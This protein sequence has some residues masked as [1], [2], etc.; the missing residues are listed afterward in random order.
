MKKTKILFPIFLSILLISSFFFTPSVNATISYYNHIQNPS[1][2]SFSDYIEDGSFESGEY[3]SGIVYGNWTGGMD[4]STDNP[5]TGIYSAK[6]EYPSLT[7]LD[8]LFASDYNETLGAD[9]IELS[10]YQDGTAGADYNFT[11]YYSDDSFDFYDGSADYGSFT[12]VDVTSIINLA[13]YVWK[14]GFSYQDGSGTTGN[15]FFD[16]FCFL[17]D[18]GG[19]QDDITENSHPWFFASIAPV[20]NGGLNTTYGRLDNSSAYTGYSNS[21]FPLQQPIEY[22]DTNY[23]HFIDLY[24]SSDYGSDI[25][26]TVLVFLSDGTSATKTMNIEADG[27]W[28]YLNFGVS[29]V[30][31]NKSI[32]SIRI[33]LDAKYET[34]VHFD[35]VGVWANVVFGY[36]RFGFSIL[37]SPI[38]KT[39]FNFVAHQN[40]QYTMNCYLYNETGALAESGDFQF[41]DNTG[42]T[43]GSF[44]NGTFSYV[45]T[46]R[47]SVSAFTEQIT[48][49][50]ILTEEVLVFQVSASWYSLDVIPDVE[51]DPFTPTETSNFMFLFIFI[52]I[53]SMFLAIIL[54]PVGIPIIG[55]LA[56]L[57][58]MTSIGRAVGIIDIW[59]LFVMVLV[60]ILIILSMLKRGLY[61]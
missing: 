61:T 28:E 16:D 35:D 26:I 2:L 36:T 22:L 42:F 9:I 34:Y 31:D 48:V 1:F 10:W 49:T 17:V 46:A 15:R 13:K 41:S 24:A 51:P 54:K 52:V 43:T 12:L 29:F 25:G 18:D 7:T 44:E 33:N 30:P 47:V 27:S 40:I 58:I 19:G 23:L 20:V 45:L 57:T 6:F 5:N 11:V 21:L 32:T 39:S 53:P 3:N 37:P 14:F 4:I 59:F 55:F 60:C 56:G 38:S 50:I 8:Y